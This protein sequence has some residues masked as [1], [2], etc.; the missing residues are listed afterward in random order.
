MGRLDTHRQ[1]KFEPSRMSY[2]V[3][4]LKG[5]GFEIAIISE[6]EINFNYK[7]SVIKFYPYSGWATGKTIKDGRGLRNL[8]QQISN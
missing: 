1:M 8:I 5:L 4:Q 7:G 2:A 6:H 3:N